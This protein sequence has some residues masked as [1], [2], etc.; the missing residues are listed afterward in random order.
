MIFCILTGGMMCVVDQDLM[1]VKKH[2]DA[3]AISECTN[4]DLHNN[5]QEEMLDLYRVNVVEKH[6]SIS[7]QMSSNSSMSASERTD[8]MSAIRHK[9]AARSR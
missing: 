1:I 7:N 6:I 3:A 4:T 8:M 9:D 2:S 5:D